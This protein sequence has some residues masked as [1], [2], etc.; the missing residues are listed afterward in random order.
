MLNTLL[1]TN[2]IQQNVQVLERR[3]DIQGCW[4]HL[5]PS[6]YREAKKI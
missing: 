4:D 6:K 2:K 5:Y 1:N 3:K